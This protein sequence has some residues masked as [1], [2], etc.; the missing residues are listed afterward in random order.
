MVGLPHEALIIDCN[1]RLAALIL[2]IEDSAVPVAGEDNH[3]ASPKL[4]DRWPTA[5]WLLALP[6]QQLTEDVAKGLLQVRE[7]A[8]VEGL[9]TLSQVVLHVDYEGDGRVVV[10]APRPITDLLQPLVDAGPSWR[11]PSAP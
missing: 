6:I 7:T 8:L 11:R 4:I 10:V 5:L 1:A 9:A 3:D 2:L